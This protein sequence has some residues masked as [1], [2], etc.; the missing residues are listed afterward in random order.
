MVLAETKVGLL[1]RHGNHSPGQLFSLSLVEAR[2]AGEESLYL[3]LVNSSSIG[4]FHVTFEWL[5]FM[6]VA[7]WE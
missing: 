5:N 1:R 2:M 6:Q 4:G 7:Q 3:K